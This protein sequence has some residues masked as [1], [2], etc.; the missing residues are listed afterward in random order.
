[1][2]VLYKEP[3]KAFE[4][5]EVENTL[6]DLQKAVGGHI[7]TFTFDD[8]ACIICDEEGVFNDKDFNCRLFTQQFFGTI[9]IAG[10][11]GDEFTDV[12]RIW[13]SLFEGVEV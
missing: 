7:E 8:D 5:R 9:L 1:M 2:K 12:P 13:A 10:I 3:G 6:E 11:D 4:I